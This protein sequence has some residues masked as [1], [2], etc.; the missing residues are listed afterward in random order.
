MEP[1]VTGREWWVV[2]DGPN[3]TESVLASICGRLPQH[4][5]RDRCF[6]QVQDYCDN[7]TCW[8]IS[9]RQ[10]YGARL[11]MPGYLDC[12]D[13]IVCQTEQECLDELSRLYDLCPAC[14]HEHENCVCAE[15]K[16]DV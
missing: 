14:W 13:W 9:E 4:A 5:S 15:P 8:A 10:G 12:T 7:R 2:V 3:G 6:K 11:S 16:E 1:E